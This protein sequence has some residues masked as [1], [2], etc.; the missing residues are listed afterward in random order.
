MSFGVEILRHTTTVLCL[1]FFC[2][3]YYSLP[4]EIIMKI[5]EYL[6]MGDL[7]SVAQVC[8]LWHQL[9]SDK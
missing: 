2:I 6:T 7:L 5:F 8:H 4:S 1:P 9:S 3:F